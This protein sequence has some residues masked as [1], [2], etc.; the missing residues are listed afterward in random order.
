MKKICLF[1]ALVLCVCTM[2]GFSV[3][4]ADDPVETAITGQLW[5]LQNTFGG[6]VDESYMVF[7]TMEA[8]RNADGG[9]SPWE[10]TVP[11]DEFEQ[12][13][14][15]YFKI[16]E[17]VLADIKAFGY[18]EYDPYEFSYNEAEDT[19]YCSIDGVPVGGIPYYAFYEYEKVGDVYKAYYCS[20]DYEF[21]SNVLPEDVDEFDYAME[22]GFPDTIEYEGKVYTQLESALTYAI[23]TR[24]YNGLVYDLEIT[25]G[26]VRILSYDEYEASDLPD[27]E[28]KME[29][30]F[31]R[32]LEFLDGYYSSNLASYAEYKMTRLL[33]HKAWDDFSDTVIPAEIFESTL[34]EYFMLDDATFALLR[35][36]TNYNEAEQTYTLAS[37]GGFG[38]GI[39]ERQY[40]GFKEKDGIYEVFYSTIL[41]DFMVDEF[42]SPDEYYAYIDELGY[43]ETVTYEGVTYTRGEYGDYEIIHGLADSGKKYTV[44]ID[45]GKV[46]VH[47]IGTFTKEEHPD[48]VPELDEIFENALFLLNGL[49]NYGFG[50]MMQELQNA[51]WDWSSSEE[52]IVLSAEEYEGMLHKLF[53]VDDTVVEQF[54]AHNEPPLIY[55]AENKTYTLYPYGGMGG[56]LAPRKYSGYG[57]NSDG[58]YDVFYKHINYEFLSDVLPDGVDEFEYAESLDWPDSIEYGGN[59]Y[60]NGPD[61]YYRIKGLDNYGQL[62]RVSVNDDYT[63]RI[64]FVK[65]FVESDLPG[66]KLGDVD[67]D[68]GI[69]ANDAIYLLYNVFF[70][71]DDYVLLQDCDFDN[72]GDVDA[73]DAIYLLYHVFF[74]EESY[75]IAPKGENNDWTGNY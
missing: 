65:D 75:P 45:G 49:Y 67:G 55:D 5:M 51:F 20:V 62:I 10:K 4:S 64:H 42:D 25:D 73:N 54:R 58:T 24:L 17:D 63:V 53:V 69:S 52:F 1:L 46:R 31:V 35:N 68:Y 48:Y 18:S 61:G 47:S 12:I 6:I 11:A 29:E 13:L 19:Y 21:L 16:D 39:A 44:D 71:D 59:T 60:G 3:N 28:E 56:I 26:A 27:Y 8:F 41:R 70:G 22:L 36:Y 66:Y 32:E 30:L 57:K 7:R 38:G 40:T 34:N 43:P 74:G 9:S 15:K 50:F 33:V 72:S 23:T 2:S 37:I 14:G